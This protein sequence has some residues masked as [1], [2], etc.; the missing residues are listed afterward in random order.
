MDKTGIIFLRC[1]N[2][3]F[4]GLHQSRWEFPCLACLESETEYWTGTFPKYIFIIYFVILLSLL[5]CILYVRIYPL[6]W[7]LK[8]PLKLLHSL[9]NKIQWKNN[10]SLRK[11]VHVSYKGSVV[12]KVFIIIS[13]FSIYIDHFNFKHRI[14]YFRFYKLF[15]L[16]YEYFSGT[17]SPFLLTLYL[18]TMEGIVLVLAALTI[19]SGKLT[20]K[21]L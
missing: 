14:Q 6:I 1:E 16:T 17:H 7:S 2:Y 21:Q 18:Q 10:E 19:S 13:L 20:Q 11:S 8:L 5:R 15:I 9:Q 3:E 4:R 12:L